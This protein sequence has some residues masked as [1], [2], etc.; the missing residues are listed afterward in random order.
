MTFDELKEMC[1]KTSRVHL[2][3]A[4]VEEGFLDIQGDI[5]FALLRSSGE[6]IGAAVPNGAE[7][8]WTQDD[9]TYMPEA[10]LKAV[11]DN[12]DARNELFGIAMHEALKA[13]AA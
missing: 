9:V 10:A 4:S 2:P 11:W 8:D 13:Q 12:D 3:F 5:V 1:G 7:I 6:V